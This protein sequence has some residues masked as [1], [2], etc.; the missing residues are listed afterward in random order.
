[1]RRC[2]AWLEEEREA[3]KPREEEKLKIELRILFVDTY[4]TN[5]NKSMYLS[6]RGYVLLKSELT[7]AEIDGI[8]KDLIISPK[9]NKAVK[10][11]KPVE[12]RKS[13]RLNSSH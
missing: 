1:M 2:Q 11:A 4:T 5:N 8:R 6:S 9:E 13:T 12:D 10:I 7:P 3:N